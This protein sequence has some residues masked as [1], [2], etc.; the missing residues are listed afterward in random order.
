MIPNPESM[1]PKILIKQNIETVVIEL[2]IYIG[3][4][5]PGRSMSYVVLAL[6][7]TYTFENC[8][9]LHVECHIEQ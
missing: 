5:Y 3:L 2:S 9:V 1:D 4:I 8:H 6:Q 7:N